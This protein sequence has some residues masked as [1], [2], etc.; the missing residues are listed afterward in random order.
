MRIVLAKLFV[1]VTALLIV[2]LALVFAT[3]RSGADHPA[4]IP[5]PEPVDFSE[6]SGLLPREGQIARGRSVFISQGC[7]KCHSI[8]GEGNPR[9][10]LD[11]V[12]GRIPEKDIR[13]WVT[14]PKTMKP[15]IVKRAYKLSE[16]ELNALVAY[17]MAED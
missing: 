12:G 16:E 1:A 10:T 14:A 4:P 3:L 17:L 11:G 6:T 5:T 7:Q 9:S 13:L 2:V 8:H 15:G